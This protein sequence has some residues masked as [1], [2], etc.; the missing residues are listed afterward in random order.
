MKCFI[1]KI[2]F[3]SVIVMTISCKSISVKEKDISY[4][5]V[6]DQENNGVMDA[7]IFVG[8][9]EMGKTDV[10]GKFFFLIPRDIDETKTVRVE[11]AGYETSILRARLVHG[12]LLYFRLF[13]SMHYAR[14]AEKL[15]DS[16]KYNEAL[17]MIEKALK[18]ERERKDYKLLKEVIELKVES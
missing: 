14:E 3:I 2:I 17:L 13:S 11:K 4:V 1:E 15:L 18:I 12:S 16:R 10:Y 9:E 6:Y 8:E 7:K 5:M